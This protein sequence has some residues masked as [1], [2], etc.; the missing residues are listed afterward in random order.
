MVEIGPWRSIWGEQS[1]WVGCKP[2]PSA[3]QTPCLPG[4]TTEAWSRLC[5]CQAFGCE[6]GSPGPALKEQ[7]RED[8][9]G[10]ECDVTISPKES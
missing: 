4:G 7:G 2:A 8:T 6:E 1:R 5:V 10:G 3:P 9:G